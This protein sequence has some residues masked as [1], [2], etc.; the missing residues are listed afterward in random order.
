MR[1]R[2]RF[3]YMEERD[4]NDGRPI[5]LPTDTFEMPVKGYELPPKDT[6]ILEAFRKY[7]II[8]FFLGGVIASWTMFSARLANAET[9]ITVLENAL[10]NITDID[11]KIAVMQ[12]DI[13][14]IK[15]RLP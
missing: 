3:N 12:N 11:L 1:V 2:K 10:N 4:L 6:S 7:W 14:Y 8:I 13:N 15:S 5:S 9:R